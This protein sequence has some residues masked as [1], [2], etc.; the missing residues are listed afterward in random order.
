M[1]LRWKVN[2]V[3]VFAVIGGAKQ[4][5]VRGCGQHGARVMRIDLHNRSGSSER[6]ERLPGGHQRETQYQTGENSSEHIGRD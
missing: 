4:Q 3:P 2:G 6:T 5:R 1:E